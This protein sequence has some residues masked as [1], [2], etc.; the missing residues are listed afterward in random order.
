M[1]EVIIMKNKIDLNELV[2]SQDRA[3][4]K[5]PAVSSSAASISKHP[6][7]GGKKFT[8]IDI[9]KLIRSI[10]YPVKLLSS[11]KKSKELIESDRNEAPQRLDAEDFEALKKLMED[12]GIKSYGSCL[13]E[14]E[15]IYAG[16][17]IPHPHA[18]VISIPMD[19]EIFRTVPSMEAQIEVMRVYGETGH[20]VNEISRFLRER[21]YTAA[22]NHSM[23]G[24]VDYAKA[25]KKAGLGYLGR[26]G[27][28]LTPESGSC[29]RL[30]VVYT[31][32]T[33]WDQFLPPRKD[34]SWMGEFCDRCG[35]CVKS[36]PSAAIRQVPEV[37]DFGNVSVVEYEKCCSGFS[38]Y[39]CGVCI[40][41]CPFTK[42]GYDKLEM[43][44]RRKQDRMNRPSASA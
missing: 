44:Y 25:G 30:A 36:C 35:K 27:M 7:P 8:F 1:S 42:I 29:H 10:S 37:D 16:N 26:N 38:H 9:L 2:E 28:L 39:G 21:G 34:Y 43:I 13:L 14:S 41:E 33:N 32:I 22:P 3:L 11:L 6:F 24:S 12:L 31:S 5:N 40:G 20:G 4:N 23:G 18:L 17:G 15:D 19:K